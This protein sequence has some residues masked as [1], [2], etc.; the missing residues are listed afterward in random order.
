MALVMDDDQFKLILDRFGYSWSGYRKV[1]KGVK[2]RIVRHMQK[3]GCRDVNEYTANLT[4]S[5]DLHSDCE[6]LLTVSISRFFR[7]KKLWEGLERQILPE[8]LNDFKGS[9]QI[10]SAGCARGEEIYSLKIV[11]D[12]LNNPAGL[13]LNAVDLNPEYIS[14]AKT[15]VYNRGSLKELSPELI[16][17]YF[18]PVR[19]RHRFEIIPELKADI[20]WQVGNLADG[21]PVS[22]YHLNF[23]RKSA[24]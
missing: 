9:I 14:A 19:G 7:D 20:S 5:A 18:S 15:G 16:S 11:W 8:L 23:A 2:K 24:L 13:T 6:K 10:L 22:N 4:D 12:L 21:L 3:I 1:R 17:T